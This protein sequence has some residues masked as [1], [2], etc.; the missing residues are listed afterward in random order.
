MLLLKTRVYECPAFQVK[1]VDTTGAGD[2]YTAGLIYGWSNG[3]SLRSTALTGSLL[4][5]L[6]ASVYGAGLA[7]PGR[8]EAIVFL[9]TSLAGNNN[10]EQQKSFK[11]IMT[12]LGSEIQSQ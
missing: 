8:Q 1:A 12:V 6:A 4:G 9:Q 3:M 5:A 2:S 10:E 11:E 7:L